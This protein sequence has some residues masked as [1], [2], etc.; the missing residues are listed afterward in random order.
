MNK[1]SSSHFAGKFPIS[2]VVTAASSAFASSF[3]SSGF[4]FAS[5]GFVSFGFV[6]SGL[7]SSGFGSSGFA[8]GFASSAR[9]LLPPAAASPGL[10]WADSRS[11][12][13]LTL[14]ISQKIAILS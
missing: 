3:V 1:G 13:S 12:S 8:S 10:G 7:V 5:S 9:N 2:T 4:A 14:Q 6:S 11:I